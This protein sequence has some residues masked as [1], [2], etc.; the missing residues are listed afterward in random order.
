MGVRVEREA[1]HASRACAI[2]STARATAR[3][4]DHAGCLL[5]ALERIERVL[6]HIDAAPSSP[7]SVAEAAALCGLS[8]AYFQRLFRAVERLPMHRRHIMPCVREN[9]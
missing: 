1:A 4:L 2:K 6:D 8:S 5:Q 3:N 9:S 7:L